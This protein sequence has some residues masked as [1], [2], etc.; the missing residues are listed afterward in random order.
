MPRPLID[1]PRDLDA[2]IAA[3]KQAR[4]ERLVRA[5]RNQRIRTKVSYVLAG[6]VALSAL[7]AHFLA[8]DAEAAVVL[9]LI[10]CLNFCLTFIAGRVARERAADALRELDQPS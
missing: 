4:R 3:S 8:G 5:A 9:T 10:A 1:T 6:C 7:A 2:A